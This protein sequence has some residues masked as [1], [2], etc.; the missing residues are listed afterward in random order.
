MLDTRSIST[1][2]FDLDDTLWA[3]GPVIRR[4]ERRLREWLESRH[5]GVFSQLSDSD[6]T[7]LKQQVFVEHA[8]RSHDMTFLRREIIARMGERSGHA[9]D[10]DAAFEVFYEARNDIELYPD[11]RPAL[12]SLAE[13]FTLIAVTNGNADLERI[14]ISDLFDGIVSARSAGAAKPH[15]QIFHAAIELAGTAAECTLHVG[16]HPQLDVDAARAAGLFAVWVNRAGH[17]WPA[18]VGEPDGVVRDL[19]D[20]DAMLGRT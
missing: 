9:I 6:I 4:A 8:D 17:D 5:P 12:V 1:I 18:G 20:L 11:V 13:R 7:T 3:I 19:G 10:V 14:G 15:P 2:T 16:D